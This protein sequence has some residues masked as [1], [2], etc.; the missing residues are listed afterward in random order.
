LYRTGG[1][2]APSSLARPM[3]LPSRTASPHICRRGQNKQAG[4]PLCLEVVLDA[5]YTQM[6]TRAHKHID[7]AVGTPAIDYQRANRRGRPAF[8]FGLGHMYS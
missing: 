8:T 2:T 6:H 3:P 1:C 7:A 4:L 5:F